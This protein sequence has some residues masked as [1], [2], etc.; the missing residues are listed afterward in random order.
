MLLVVGS[1]LGELSSNYHT[2][3]PHGRVVQVDADRGVLGANVSALG[4]HADAGL[5]LRALAE[6]VTPRPADGD[7][8]RRVATLLDTVRSRIAGQGLDVE[9]RVLTAVREALPPEATSCWDMTILGYWAWSAWDPCEG[10]MHSAQGAGGLGYAYPAALGVAAAHR[11][12]GGTHGRRPVLAVSGDGGAMYGVAELATAVQHGLDVTWLIVDD[13]GYGVL[14]E[15]MRDS[16]GSP[17]APSWLGP[18]SSRWRGRSAYPPS[19]A[20][21]RACAATSPPTWHVRAPAS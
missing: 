2:L 20:A 11:A 3:A 12:A 6:A 13:G 9:Q 18:T 19:A 16:F 15:Y 4:I 10:A 17:P 1:G 14:R 7:A 21:W 8:E 5:T